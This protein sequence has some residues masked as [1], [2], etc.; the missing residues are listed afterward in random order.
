MASKK[1]NQQEKAPL[2]PILTTT[3]F[4]MVCIDY[5]KLGLCKGGFKYVLVVTDHFTRFSQ[6]YATKGNKS[7]EAANKIFNEFVLQFGMPQK[8]HHDRGQEFN[9]G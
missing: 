3:P 4:E 6:A 8:I 9:S 7:K 2:V 1:Q 5:L